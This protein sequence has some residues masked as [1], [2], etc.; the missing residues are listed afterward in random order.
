[1]SP[2]ISKIYYNDLK[3]ALF[4]GSEKEIAEK[5]F[6]AYNN[7]MF[8]LMTNKE[9]IETGLRPQGIA[10]DAH[11]NVM[12]SIN[13]MNP[14]RFDERSKYSK[15]SDLDAY[16]VWERENVDKIGKDKVQKAS[17]YF[18]YFMKNRLKKIMNNPAYRK[19]YVEFYK[20]TKPITKD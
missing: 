18:Q 6:A 8:E 2:S 13:M 14:L 20:D 17:N 12:Q 7:E 11:K 1:M 9:N 4:F 5:Y 16:R 19:E 3:D 10:N 15:K